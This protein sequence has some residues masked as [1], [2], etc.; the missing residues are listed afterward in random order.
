MNFKK[1]IFAM[2]RQDT[3]TLVFPE[4]NFSDKVMQAVNIITSQKL[5]KVI[6]I[7]SQ[8]TLFAKYSSL[9]NQFLKIIDPLTSDLRF[10]VANIINAKR[11]EK[12]ITLQKA[13]ELAQDPYYFATG[14]VLLNYADGL[15]SGAESITSK[16]YLPALELI[17]GINDDA[18]LSSAVIFVGKNKYIKN[19]PLLLAD[20]ALNINPSATQI[21]DIARAS[22]DLW[23]T[24]FLEEPKL[25]FLSYSTNQSAKGDSVLKMRTA[26]KMFQSECP[27]IISDGEMQLDCALNPK[28]QAKKFPESKIKG[29]ANILIVPDLAS[30]SI[31]AKSLSV[32][33]GLKCIGP[34]SLGFKKPVSD[35]SRSATV[36]EIVLI[37]AIT[38]IQAQVELN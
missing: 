26:A 20:P 27:E 33:G 7:G 32:V 36:E 29:D 22:A 28:T 19:R 2:A 4:A 16:T 11:K 8:S 14:L 5:A 24:L 13:Q 12:G 37:S 1:Q 3:K 15:V 9:E 38:A 18:F 23:K 10:E 17:K 34:I 6:L 31:L 30:G 35:L 25:A 21:V